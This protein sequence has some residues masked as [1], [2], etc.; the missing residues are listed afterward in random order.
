MLRRMVNM[1]QWKARIYQ[2]GDETKII[3]LMNM[4]FRQK[5]DLGFWFWKYKTAPRGFLS[6]VAEDHGK[7][8]GHLGLQLVDVKVGNKI[9]MGSQACDL[10]VNPD[11]RG[12]GIFVELLKTL[13]K[14][15]KDEKVFF[16]HSFSTDEACYGYIKY[17]WFDVSRMPVLVTYYDTYRALEGRLKRLKGSK[18]VLRSAK[19]SDKFFSIRRRNALKAVENTEIAQI[20]C[21]G[22]GIDRVWNEVSK[23]YG[24][25]IVKDCKYLNWRY[26][27]KPNA[28]YHVIVARIGGDIQ[29]YA[30]L[31]K[32][33]SQSGTRDIGYI[34]DILSI[35]KSALFGLVNA[36]NAY[37]SKQSVDSVRC[38][39]QQNQAEYQVLKKCGFLT[40]PSL[41]RRLI[42]CVNS[43]ELLQTYREAGDW[44]VDA[45]DSDWV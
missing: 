33:K 19:Y 11:Y 40:I 28:H 15:A 44:Y 10:C 5:N 27:A 26:F 21:F 2:E 8:V 7:I 18:L 39:T 24:I 42:A 29:G 30:V 3:D 12:Q 9:I 23:R 38:W 25:M 20:S 41:R 36:S 13:M 32:S 31:S 34:L 4:V 1:K 17:G 43:N 45:G 14:K 22:R 37:L 16:T 6:V 35:S